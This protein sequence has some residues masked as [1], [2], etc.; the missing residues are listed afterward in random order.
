VEFVILGVV[1]AVVFLATLVGFLRAPSRRRL[2]PPPA[3]TSTVDA[4]PAAPAQLT[5]TP[6]P[7]PTPAT[8]TV[9]APPVI[10]AEQAPA[11]EVPPPSAGRL[12]RLRS[13]LA[14]SESGFGRGLLALLSRDTID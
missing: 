8:A 9:E 5:P 14:R 1:I 4:P 13:R 7:T 3:D 12:V 11:L 10:A 2:P 6:T